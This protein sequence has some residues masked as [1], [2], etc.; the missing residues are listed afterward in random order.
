MQQNICFITELVI[1]A[2]QSKHFNYT[3]PL[4]IVSENSLKAWIYED[5]SKVLLWARFRTILKNSISFLITFRWNCCLKR[6]H[7]N[8]NTKRI[9]EILRSRCLGTLWEH[10]FHHHGMHRRANGSKVRFVALWNEDLWQNGPAEPFNHHQLQS[11]EWNQRLHTMIHKKEAN[12]HMSH[13]YCWKCQTGTRWPPKHQS[14]EK[15][16]YFFGFRD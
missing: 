12:S 11:F 1:E 15:N 2:V 7:K 9:V 8:E 5:F 13:L 16:R 4:S 3:A 14:H 6:E 10:L